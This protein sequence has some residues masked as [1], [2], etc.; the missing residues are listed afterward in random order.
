M[1]AV[2]DTR[3]A[4]PGRSSIPRASARL[5][6]DGLVGVGRAARSALQEVGS[7]ALMTARVG[8]AIV[9][10]PFELR[11]IVHQMEEIGIRSVGIAAVT[12]TFTGMVMC[13]Q[14]LVSLSKFGARDLVGTAM[15]VAIARELGPVLT[16]LM[17]GGRVGA[18]MAAEVGSMAVTEQLDAIRALGADPMKKVVLPR[19]V[20]AM[21]VLP[22]LTILADVLGFLGAGV[23]AN[24]EAGVEYSHFITSG[25]QQLKI[26]D[27]MSGIGK[28]VVFGYLIAILGCHHGFWTTGG[29]EGV[30]RST[31]RTVV[32]TSTAILIADFLLTKLFLML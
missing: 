26:S 20:A 30:G 10:R 29:T 23:I 21:I 16:A 32:V 9:R 25:I 4:P 7:V 18:G 27:F 22:L 15:A 6:G 3:P 1:S 17:V 8:R 2:D 12:A 14:S 19:V 13:L 31:T 5:A 28:T 24:V 11:E